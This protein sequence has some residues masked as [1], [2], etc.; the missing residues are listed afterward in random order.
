MRDRAAAL[1]LAALA[2][3]LVAGCRG[4][5]ADGVPTVRADRRP[6]AVSVEAGG[7]LAAKD[8]ISISPARARSA[9]IIAWL[10]PEGSQVGEGDLVAEFEANEARDAYAR[11]DATVREIRQE[12]AKHGVQVDTRR[13]DLTSEITRAEITKEKAGFRA[14]LDDGIL[15]RIE[16]E[17]AKMD[18]RLAEIDLDRLARAVES[19]KPQE[20]A[21]LELLEIKLRKAMNER[22][23]AQMVLDATRLLAPSDGVVAYNQVWKSGG[24]DKV[25]PGDPVWPGRP[26]LNLVDLAGMEFVAQVREQD[27]VHVAEGQPAHVTLS[28]YPGH[29]IS[30]RV[31]QVAA[32]SQQVDRRNPVKQLEVR[33]ALEDTNGLRLFAGLTG[34]ARIEVASSEDAITVP[35]E[36]VLGE[37]G[38]SFV[39]VRNG[40]GPEKRSVVTGIQGDAEIVLAEGVTDGERVFVRDPTKTEEE[41]LAE[42]RERQMEARAK[43]KS[44]AGSGTSVVIF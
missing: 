40:S 39:Y 32:R 20:R 11:A 26:V 6:F 33:L 7:E 28:A 1:V 16:T 34:S 42:R 30:A 29:S 14:A 17:Q 36:A 44:T 4:G 19:R 5:G 12:I 9:L 22:D 13:A 21:A 31:R 37:N 2:A 15:P 23:M 43:R 25:A 27:A 10:A 24:L 8:S 35:R 3:A 41:I 18:L 38:A